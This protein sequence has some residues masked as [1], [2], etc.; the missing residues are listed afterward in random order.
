MK[1]DEAKKSVGAAEALDD[2]FKHAV[3]ESAND[4]LAPK[5]VRESMKQLDKRLRNEK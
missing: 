4:P 1:S 3:R 2:A 5:R